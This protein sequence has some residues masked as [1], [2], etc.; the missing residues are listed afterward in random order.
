MS[1]VHDT[2]V[3]ERTY[4]AAP[5]RVFAAWSTQ[6]AKSQWFGGEHDG[7]TEEHTLDFRVGGREHLSGKIPDG[8]TFT[9]DAVYQDIVD[10]ERAVWAYDMHMD[11]RRIPACRVAR[12]SSSP[13]RARTSTGWTPAPSARKAPRSCST[14]SVP[15]CPPELP[16]RPQPPKLSYQ[17]WRLS[18]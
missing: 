9:Y 6:A 7:A 8:P 15:S 10:G 18:P 2:F 17:E 16:A 3:I 14:S 5:E 11:G 13:S 4:P 1:V 12:S